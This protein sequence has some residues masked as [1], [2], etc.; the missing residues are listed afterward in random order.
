MSEQTLS[1]IRRFMEAF[2]NPGSPV[3]EEAVAPDFVTHHPTLPPM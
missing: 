2:E 1:L 3:L